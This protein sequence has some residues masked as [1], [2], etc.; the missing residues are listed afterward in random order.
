[1]IFKTVA[2]DTFSAAWIRTVANTGVSGFIA[3]HIIYIFR[4]A[5]NLS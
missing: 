4:I 5:S 2:T 1:V 3:F